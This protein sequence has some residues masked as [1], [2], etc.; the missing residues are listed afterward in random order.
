[1]DVP[2]L[3][4]DLFPL[5][6]VELGESFGENFGDV[7]LGDLFSSYSNNGLYEVWAERLW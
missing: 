4:S 6:G 3:P 2:P 1:M 5:G 7:A